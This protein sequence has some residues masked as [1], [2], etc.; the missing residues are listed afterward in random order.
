MT[1]TA[2]ITTKCPEWCTSKEIE[3]HAKD[4]HDGPSWPS[5]PNNGGFQSVEIGVQMFKGEQLSVVV[6]APTVELTAEEA[7]KVGQFL[8][9]AGRW[10]L[11]H[12]VA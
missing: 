1:I 10:A 5:L 2:T 9:E 6:N 4:G 12:R 8:I 3:D 7:L 11:A